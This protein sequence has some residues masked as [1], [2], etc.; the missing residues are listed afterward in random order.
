MDVDHLLETLPLRHSSFESS[1]SSSSSISRSF[2]RL[3]EFRASDSD[4]TQ[5]IDGALELGCLLLKAGN[6]SGRKC[7][8]KRNSLAWALRPD[9][10]M[11]VWLCQ[12]HLRYLIMHF[13]VGYVILFLFRFRIGI[14]VC[15][16]W[17]LRCLILFAFCCFYGN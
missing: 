4:Q 9:L 12:N 3:P 8:S 5:L 14:N 17:W 1:S 2:K 6:R 15:E 7:A 11:K 16:I 13:D 10:T